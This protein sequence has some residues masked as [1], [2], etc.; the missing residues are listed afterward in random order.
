MAEVTNA[1]IDATGMVEWIVRLQNQYRAVF[2]PNLEFEPASV[3]QQLIGIDAENYAEFDEALVSVNNGQSLD[4]ATDYQLDW[5]G[6]QLGLPRLSDTPSTVVLTLTGVAG[7]VIRR[8]ARSQDTEGHIFALVNPATLDS[9]GTADAVAE[10]VEGGALNVPPGAII[11]IIDVISG[12]ERVVNNAAAIPGRDIETD[13]D[14][15]V[16][17]TRLIGRN[18]IGSIDS[19]KAA[20]LEVPGVTK[21]AVPENSTTSTMLVSGVSIGNGRMYI[22]V[23]GGT[24]TDVAEAIYNSR[25]AGSRTAGAVLVNLPKNTWTVPIR[26]NRPVETPIT[27]SLTITPL[28]GFPTDGLAQ[29]RQALLDLV[30]TLEIGEPMYDGFAYVAVLGIQKIRLVG[31]I[32]IARKAA[33]DPVTE[34][35]GNELF[36]LASTDIAIT[37]QS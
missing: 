19:I 27:I 6:T 14:Y 2:G 4:S 30:D 16:R 24:N 20:I 1:G 3:Q 26:F 7:T 23:K 22:V 31:A 36:T 29:I 15:R 25:P 13:R 28:D 35:N 18:T 17:M 32:V 11:R 5:I 10:A 34:V 21:A 37:V 33:G 8:G 9:D 12:W